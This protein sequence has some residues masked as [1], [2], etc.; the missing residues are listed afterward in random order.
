MQKAITPT[1]INF[2]NPFIG[3]FFVYLGA[4]LRKENQA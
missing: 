4:R 3:A 2:V 1:W